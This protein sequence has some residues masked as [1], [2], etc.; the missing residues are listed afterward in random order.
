VKT[1]EQ[2][3][4]VTAAYA[5]NYSPRVELKRRYGPHNMLNMNHNIAP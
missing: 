2:D 5:S 1:E 3:A 4:H